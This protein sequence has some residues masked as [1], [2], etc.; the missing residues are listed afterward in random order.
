MSDCRFEAFDFQFWDLDFGIW[1]LDFFL[2]YGRIFYKMIP[3]N[4]I[5]WRPTNQDITTSRLYE[6]RQWLKD[7]HGIET[8]DYE[9]LWQW[10]VDHVETFWESI[11]SFFD[12]KLHSPYS[13]VISGGEMPDTV[14][15]DGAEL[16]YAEHIS[17]GMAGHNAAILF[18]S[19]KD[20]LQPDQCR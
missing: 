1:N 19:E 7:H 3:Q 13:S 10:S 5:L 12:V 6:Y 15:F 2:P 17:R 8:D 11:I 16:N 18:A 20:E 14:W 9:A 4:E